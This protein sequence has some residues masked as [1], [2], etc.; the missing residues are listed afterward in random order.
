MENNGFVNSLISGSRKSSMFCEARITELSFLRTRF[1]ALRIYSMAVRL[2]RK[3]YNSSMEATVFPMPRSLLL[4]YDKILKSIASLRRR[5]V[6]SKPF[7][8]KHRKLYQNLI[9][10]IMIG[11]QLDA[12]YQP[13]QNLVRK[14]V[15]FMEVTNE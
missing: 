14:T 4:I 8:P 2:L 9:R 10:N 6:S 12:M 5:F 13:S 15:G 1:M 11:S 7:T 3:R